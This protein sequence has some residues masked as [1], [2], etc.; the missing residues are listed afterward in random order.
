LA[1]AIAYARNLR[2]PNS[3]HGTLHWRRLN[4]S[5]D[6]NTA[7]L[8]TDQTLIEA[9][10]D[11]G[12]EVGEKFWHYLSTTST[13]SRSRV[14]SLISRTLAERSR[15]HHRRGVLKEFAEDTSWAH[16]DIAGTAW[17]DPAT[18][19]DPKANGV[20]VRTLIEFIER[21]ARQDGN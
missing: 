20:A 21:S 10:I 13:P 3:R 16:L 1:D 8:G 2:H 4:R 19:I 14:I 9:V 15:D 7:I 18:P 11:A 12:K 6:V 17:G 5:G